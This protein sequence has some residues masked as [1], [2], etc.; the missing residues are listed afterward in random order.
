MLVYINFRNLYLIDR[1]RENSCCKFVRYVPWPSPSLCYL[2]SPNFWQG[3]DK[4]H[5]WQSFFQRTLASDW[6]CINCPSAMSIRP[7]NPRQGFAF[8]PFHSRPPQQSTSERETFTQRVAFDNYSFFNDTG[9][10]LLKPSPL[11]VRHSRRSF[12]LPHF[13]W[14]TAGFYIYYHIGASKGLV[15]LSQELS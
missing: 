15:A 5:L 14:S 8:H 1:K 4:V 2:V 13:L 3:K 7:R 10:I 6:L 9:S 12:L 11:Y